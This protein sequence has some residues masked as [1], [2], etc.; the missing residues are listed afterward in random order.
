M[1]GDTQTLKN[2]TSNADYPELPGQVS[3]AVTVRK[4][5]DEAYGSEYRYRFSDGEHTLKVRNTV[6]KATAAKPQMNRHNVEMTYNRFADEANGIPAA[7]FQAYLVCRYPSSEAG[8][9][10]KAL[11][12]ALSYYITGSSSAAN[13]LKIFNFES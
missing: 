12:Y 9:E 3:D 6:E 8:D 4:V 13:F 10:A 7:T 2:Q 1:L 5:S 11:A